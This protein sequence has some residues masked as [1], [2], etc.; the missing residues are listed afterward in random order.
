[1]FRTSSFHDLLHR[2]TANLSAIDWACLEQNFKKMA[3]DK[4]GGLTLEEFKKIV[5]AK[6]VKLYQP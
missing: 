2:R 6:N 1:M 3:R 4:S 5:P